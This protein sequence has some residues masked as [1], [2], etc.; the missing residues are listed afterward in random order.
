MRL[1]M[2]FGRHRFR[3]GDYNIGRHERGGLKYF[4]A[5]IAGRGGI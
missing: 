3:S 1:A 4:T 2:T 5:P